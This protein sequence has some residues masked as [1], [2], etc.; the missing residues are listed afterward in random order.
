MRRPGY[1]RDVALRALTAATLALALGSC[2]GGPKESTVLVDRNKQPPF[3]NSLDLDTDG[4]ILL[5]T[6]KGFFRIDKDGVE[7]KPI[8]GKITDKGKTSTLGTFLEFKVLGKD[9][10]IG[11]GHPDQKGTLPQYLGLIRTEDGGKTWKAVSRMSISDLHDME[12]LHGRLYAFD[13][14]LGGLLISKDEGR[15]WVEEFTPQELVLDIAVDP[16]DPAYILIT[17]R[18]SMFVTTNEG[19]SWRPLG[20]V[21]S[22]RFAWPTP[23]VLYRAEMRGRFQVSSDRGITWRD[24]GN[25]GG[26][27]W[28][29]LA[30]DEQNL[31][32][33]LVDGTIKVSDDGGKSWEVRF[34]A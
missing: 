23:T 27:P 1:R 18:D 28:A 2:G 3:I 21:P 5:S 30:V 10:M 20:R 4:S 8:T 26:E 15:T 13:A 12:L 29:L 16:R 7:A 31:Y 34:Q 25:V 6:N 22:P 17:T 14:V 33:A 19:K 9:R 32:V 24:V 11:S